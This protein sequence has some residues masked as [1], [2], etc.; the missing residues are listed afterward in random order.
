MVIK[1]STFFLFILLIGLSYS[2]Q[3]CV[4]VID[5]TDGPDDPICQSSEAECIDNVCFYDTIA[6]CCHTYDDCVGIVLDACESGY[7]CNLDSHQCEVQL[8]QCENGQPCTDFCFD[9]LESCETRVCVASDDPDVDAT[10]QINITPFE[11]PAPTNRCMEAYCSGG[12]EGCLTYD[13]ECEDN[14]GCTED[15]CAGTICEHTPIE[16]CTECFG[17]GCI[18]TDACLPSEC[19]EIDYYGRQLRGD[20]PF[21]E[22]KITPLNCTIDDPCLINGVCMDGKCEYE[23]ICSSEAPAT[24]EVTTSE[25]TTTGSITT[26]ASTIGQVTTTAST[27]ATTASTI[28]T[29]TS[30]I[31]TTGSLS[32]TGG[33]ASTIATTASTIATTTGV[34]TASTSTISS[35][36]STT[37][38]NEPDDYHGPKYPDCLDCKDLGCEEMGK[39]CKYLKSEKKVCVDEH[40]KHHKSPKPVCS[41]KCPPNHECK[42]DEFDKQCCVKIHCE[43]LCY[44]DCGRGFECKIKHDGSQ[45]CVKSHRPPPPPPPRCSLRCPPN[46]ECKIDEF[47]KQCCVKIHCEEVCDLD[48]GRGFECK[49]KHDGSQCCVKSHRNSK[50]GYDN[51]NY[52][53]YEIQSKYIYGNNGDYYEDGYDLDDYNEDFIIFKNKKY[54]RRLGPYD[55]CPYTPTCY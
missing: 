11:C 30:E 20:G 25:I 18:T 55:C 24:T 4:N 5:C 43:E 21:Y 26:T 42:V 33:A 29:T 34:T 32:T 16:N 50:L 13:T 22:C 36:T 3:A 41:L 45:C 27:I 2:Q 12:P 54:P 37:G 40:H 1:F 10:C 15:I 8:K 38:G 6:N 44:L 7:T 48:C 14:V 35:T 53:N 46:H 28:A 17:L 23:N 39:K 49:I 31:T 51:D 47:G 9:N 52:G 19:V